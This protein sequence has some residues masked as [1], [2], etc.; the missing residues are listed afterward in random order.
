MSENTVGAVVGA[1]DKAELTLF[2]AISVTHTNSSELI[3]RLYSQIGVN[4]GFKIIHFL[5]AL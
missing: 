1:H 4:F 3:F 2:S 5:L